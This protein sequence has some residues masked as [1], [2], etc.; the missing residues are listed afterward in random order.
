MQKM[1]HFFPKRQQKRE[2]R[3]L[4]GRLLRKARGISRNRPCSDRSGQAA[5]LSAQGQFNGGEDGA[6]PGVIGDG[7]LVAGAEDHRQGRVGGGN[8]IVGVV[9]DELDIVDAVAI[10][11][12]GAD[13]GNGALSS[14]RPF[15]ASILR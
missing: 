7:D 2:R 8:G 13:V 14:M 12:G 11:D 10:L 4:F 1:G 15:S 6:L 5:L 3:R 9:A